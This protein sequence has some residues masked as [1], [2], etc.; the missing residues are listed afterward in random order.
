MQNSDI[1]KAKGLDTEIDGAG[2][3]RYF[4][5]ALGTVLRA[6]KKR[7][8]VGEATQHNAGHRQINHGLAS[9]GLEFIVFA[10]AAKTA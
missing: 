6:C 9:V 3:F 7:S 10:E 2:Y 1:E 8:R 5:I 4:A